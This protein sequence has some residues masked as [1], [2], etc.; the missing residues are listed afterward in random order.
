[1]TD[2]LN[3]AGEETTAF[4]EKRRPVYQYFWESQFFTNIKKRGQ[5]FKIDI[6]FYY[7]SFCQIQRS[8]PF[9]HS[10]E[11]GVINS[12]PSLFNGGHKIFNNFVILHLAFPLCQIGIHIVA[13]HEI[14]LIIDWPAEIAGEVTP[15]SSAEVPMAL[16][17]FL[18][19][20]LQLRSTLSGNT[21]CRRRGQRFCVPVSFPFH[22]L[23]EKTSVF[24][25]MG[26]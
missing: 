13:G 11:H 21:R 4:K 14:V 26:L 6:N 22:S 23:G 24:L 25:L 20:R 3:R 2:K 1:M 5:I 18:R 19:R 17:R 15:D 9:F 8:D 16:P 12:S 7:K 10:S